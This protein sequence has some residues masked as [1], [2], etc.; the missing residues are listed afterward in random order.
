[1]RRLL[2]LHRRGER[3]AHDREMALRHRA[4]ALPHRAGLRGDARQAHLLSAAA[5]TKKSPPSRRAFSW[6]RRSAIVLASFPVGVLRILLR[7]AEVLLHL[8]HRFLADALGLLARVVGG[9]ADVLADLA[10][11]LLRDALHLV[12]VH[13]DLS[14]RDGRGRPAVSAGRMH[15][16]PE[17]RRLGSGAI[18]ARSRAR[19]TTE[20]LQ[21]NLTST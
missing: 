17:G 15:V 19:R 12:L 9:L 7:V 16:G 8:A 14:L 18:S 3:R 6:A 2:R 20:F 5:R 13:A 4:R 10:F 11:R 21:E 1:G